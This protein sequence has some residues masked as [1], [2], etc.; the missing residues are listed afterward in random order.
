MFTW[1][2]MLLYIAWGFGGVI[3]NTY[4]STLQDTVLD[5][6]KSQDSSLLNL[7]RLQF[8]CLHFWFDGIVHFLVN[9]LTILKK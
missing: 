6:D 8:F 2:I 9:L 4:K 3:L 1:Y 7:L 5:K